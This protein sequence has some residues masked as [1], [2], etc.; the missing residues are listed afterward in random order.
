MLL[1]L[2]CHTAEA[3]LLGWGGGVYAVSAKS[4]PRRVGPVRS[5]G[6][7]SMFFRCLLVGK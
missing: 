7:I 1:G 3:G 4:G 2:A 5:L 6:V